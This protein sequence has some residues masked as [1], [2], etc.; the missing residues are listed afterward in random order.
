M[1]IDWSNLDAMTNDA[2]KPLY[3][4]R[5]RY[6]V[7]WGGAGSGKSVFVGQRG[8]YRQTAEPGHNWLILRSF[9]TLNRHSTYPLIKSV[10]S[11]FN[12]IDLYRVNKSDMTI[13]NRINKNQIMF[14]GLDDVEKLKSI[15]F[16][17]GPL[18][19]VWLE[20][21][22]Q[23]KPTDWTQLDLRLR[24]IA[25]V[26]FQFTVTFNPVNIFS[27]LKTLIDDNKD[28]PD[29]TFLHTTYLDNKFVGPEYYRVLEGLKGAAR[30]VYKDGEWGQQEGLVFPE[31]LVDDYPEDAKLMGY[32][33]DW[34]FTNDPSTL[35][36]VYIK[37]TDI[38][39]DEEF[40]LYGMTN[41]AIIA[42]YKL[43]GI[44]KYAEI[45]A[46]N[47]EPKSIDD[48]FKA[49]YNVHPCIKGPDSIRYTISAVKEYTLHITP[50]S[51][52]LIKEIYA[53]AWKKNKEGK[54]L[55]E[56]VDAFNH[57]IDAG[58]YRTTHTV[59]QAK[60]GK[61]PAKHLGL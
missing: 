37:G 15:T 11:D 53:Y 6:N 38:W 56:P 44:S 58:R 22:T 32:G 29:Y 54:E 27:Y 45:I 10:V 34:G 18:T 13:T 16:E 14:A 4:D 31:F 61:V 36:G 21:G 30:K 19:D 59:M 5:N 47:S 9:A 20:E 55:Q 50:R 48:L 2:Y 26:P 41:P 12:L 3:R 23:T 7:I 1:T 17:N 25:K 8:I 49:G 40:Y 42:Q 57:A 33:Q 52:N 51:Q 43:L 60:A 39:W 24:G 28:N 46:D 35:V